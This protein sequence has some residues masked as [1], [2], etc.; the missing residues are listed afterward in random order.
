MPSFFDDVCEYV[1]HGQ[2][3]NDTVMPKEHSVSNVTLLIMWPR[4][5]YHIL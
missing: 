1:S 3:V 5:Y 4:L 2:L